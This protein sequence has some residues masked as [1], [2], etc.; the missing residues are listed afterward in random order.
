MKLV[1]ED[2][3]ELDF[4]PVK[5]RPIEGY[6][7]VKLGQAFRLPNG[8]EGGAEDWIVVNPG[9]TPTV[10]SSG[11]FVEQYQ[12]VIKRAP[13]PTAEAALPDPPDPEDDGE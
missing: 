13:K 11:A 6:G 8:A 3:G 4:S 2:I 9:G 12:R 5:T 7:A 1:I 10:V